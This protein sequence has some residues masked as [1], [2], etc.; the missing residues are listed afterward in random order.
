MS[1]LTSILILP[2]LVANAEFSITSCPDQLLAV[3]DNSAKLDLSIYATDGGVR[4]VSVA[5]STEFFDCHDARTFRTVEIV[6]TDNSGNEALCFPTISV[7]STVRPESIS[8]PTSLLL[9]LSTRCS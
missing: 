1:R 9:T 3:D 7:S 4:P 8:R 2:V 6:A 5:A